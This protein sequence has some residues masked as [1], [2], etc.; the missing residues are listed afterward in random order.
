MLALKILD[1]KSRH[2]LKNLLAEI[3]PKSWMQ[4]YD[5]KMFLPMLVRAT[6]YLNPHV[7]QVPSTQGAHAT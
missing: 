4:D 5:R 2:A 7:A 3:G 1:L 6:K